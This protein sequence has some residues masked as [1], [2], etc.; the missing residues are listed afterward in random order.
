MRLYF[1]ITFHFSCLVIL[2]FSFKVDI[3]TTEKRYGVGFLEHR[4]FPGRL[5]QLTVMGMVRHFLKLS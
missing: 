3:E 2:S 1:V 5:Q 4:G